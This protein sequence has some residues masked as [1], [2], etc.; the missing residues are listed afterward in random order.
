LIDLLNDYAKSQSILLIVYGYGLHS[1]M[2]P[3]VTA[4]RPHGIQK[5]GA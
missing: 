3:L 4:P 1:L 2:T 5:F